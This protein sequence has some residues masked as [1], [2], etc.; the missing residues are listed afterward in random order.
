MAS[1]ETLGKLAPS[2]A[3]FAAKL[4]LG[5]HVPGAMAQATLEFLLKDAYPEY[6]SRRKAERI[7]EDIAD[8]AV[9]HL[10]KV[11]DAEATD[12]AVIDPILAA[13]SDTFSTAN[14]TIEDVAAMNFKADK[15]FAAVLSASPSYIQA[16]YG[17]SEKLLFSGFDV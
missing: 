4:T 8:R 3:L 15:V 10:L 9:G 12:S 13:L 7:F 14:I 11:M 2:I 1:S 16:S 17:E 5:S 6:L